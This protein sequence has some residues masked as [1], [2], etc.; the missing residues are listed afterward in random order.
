MVALINLKIFGIISFI[1]PCLID[2]KLNTKWICIGT[3]IH[4]YKYVPSICNN[5]FQG[6]VFINE[7]KL[8]SVNPKKGKLVQLILVINRK[9]PLPQKPTWNL[10]I[11][12][13][14]HIETSGYCI[15]HTNEPQATLIELITCFHRRKL[16]VCNDNTPFFIYPWLKKLSVTLVT[17]NNTSYYPGEWRYSLK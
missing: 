15:H 17:C 10:Y 12:Q 1:H 6:R 16:V 4:L 5:R 14:S 13:F 2:I 8:E 3:I 9:V 7:I 11:Q